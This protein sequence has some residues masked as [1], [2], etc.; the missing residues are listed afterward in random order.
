[1]PRQ[2]CAGHGGGSGDGRASPRTRPLAGVASL[3]AVGLA[4]GIAAPAG[5][6]PAEGGAFLDAQAASGRTAYGRS[7]ASCHGTTLRGVDHGPELT[8]PGFLGNWGSQTAAAL[9]EYVRAEMP[10]GLGGSLPSGTYLSIVAYLLQANGHAAGP[11]A[12]TADAADL[13]GEPGAAPA[14]GAPATADASDAALAESDAA[15]ADEPRDVDAVPGLRAFVNREV[16][17]LTPV[18]DELLRN[19]P[20]EDWLTWR[21]TRDN[22]GYTPLDQIGPDN[23][24]GLHLAWALAMPEGTNQTAPLVHDGVM[25]L[26]SP[27]N[28]V[29]ALDAATGEL[30]WEHRHQYPD[31]AESRRA[32]R[33]IALYRD[34]VYLATYD[35]ALVA[36]DAR[37]GEPVWRT[38]RAD[39]RKG[40]AQTGGPSIA[41]GVVVSGINGCER[42]E[43]EGCFITGHDP[44]TGEELW[45]TSTIAQPG[46]VNSGPGATSRR[47]CAA[48]AT[49]G[50]RAPTTPTSTSSSS[51]PRRRSRGWRRAA[52]CRRTT[53]PSTPTRRSP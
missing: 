1:M 13:V 25:F 50:F 53:T 5:A 31:D 51:A 17:G 7:C 33:S 32:T 49:P 48:A 35:A 38:T 24:A 29:Q 19:P 27:G 16:S 22:H 2:T 40:F 34:K 46:D 12:L 3:A 11:R 37:T 23:V 52:G 26:A 8:G 44:D 30:L 45:R 18:T 6:Q 43:D 42:F 21:R 41:N 39:Y 28:V 15:A 20:A 4:F 36:L 14:G 47:T 10:P 9:Y